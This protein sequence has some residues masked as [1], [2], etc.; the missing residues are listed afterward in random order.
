MPQRNR[1]GARSHRRRLLSLAVLIACLW[2][3]S[4]GWAAEDGGDDV[5]LLFLYGRP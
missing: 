3:P 2:G 5:P 4:P 1:S